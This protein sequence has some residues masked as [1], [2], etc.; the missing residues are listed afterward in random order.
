[1]RVLGSGGVPQPKRVLRTGLAVVH[2]NELVFPAVGSEAE[3]E[4]AIADARTTVQMVFPV[5]I[6]VTG[7]DEDDPE[8]PAG[9]IVSRAAAR[10]RSA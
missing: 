2:E 6:E 9:R 8:Q 3:A 1:M 7:G 10:L 5:E 4:A